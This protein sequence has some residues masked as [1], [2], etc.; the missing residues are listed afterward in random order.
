MEHRYP[1]TVLTQKLCY[2]VTDGK[3]QVEGRGLVIFP[4]VAYNI[5][6][7]FLVDRPTTDVDSNVFS[8]VLGL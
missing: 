7:H 6:E 5:F 1:L 3:K 2:L 4:L 8:L